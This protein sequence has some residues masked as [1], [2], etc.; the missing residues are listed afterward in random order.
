M[1]TRASR[2]SSSFPSRVDG[3]PLSRKYPLK[4]ML[5]VEASESQNSRP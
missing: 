2:F 3:A 5:A 1:I 4:P